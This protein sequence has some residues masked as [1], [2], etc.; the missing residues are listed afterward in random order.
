MGLLSGIAGTIVSKAVGSIF[1]GGGTPSSAAPTSKT[2]VVQTGDQSVGL[3]ARSVMSGRQ[4]MQTNTYN[5]TPYRGAAPTSSPRGLKS[6]PAISDESI[7]WGNLFN[8]YINQ[9][10][11]TMPVS[12]KEQH[13]PFRR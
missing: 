13:G 4:Q 10:Q 12:V 9:A 1:G 7:F 11:A 2:T 8:K 6:A 5:A 3:L